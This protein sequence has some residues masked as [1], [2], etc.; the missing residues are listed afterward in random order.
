MLSITSAQLSAW[1]GA[2]LLPFFRVLALLSSA[3]V[4]SA[5]QVSLRLRI[6]LAL[7]IALVIAPTLPPMPAVEPLSVAS[8]LLIGQQI[9]IGLAMG[10]TMRLVFTAVEFAGH[11]IGLQMG[12]GFATLMDPQNGAQVPVLSHF[13]V[14]LATLVFLASNAHLMLIAALA[15][16]FH[17][18]PVAIGQGLDVHAWRLLVNWG[19]T[20]FK[21]GIILA[22]PIIGVLLVA[23]VALAVLSKAAPQLNIFVIGFPLLLGLGFG[24]LI[25]VLPYVAPLLDRAMDDSLRMVLQVLRVLPLPGHP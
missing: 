12:L 19:G 4:F 20:I 18:F 23:N 8:A 6:G 7:L 5:P 24:G 14:L 3:P 16:S 25:L 2:L 22:L 17:Y 1:V 10:F 11:V 15:E 13:L 21:T 9:L